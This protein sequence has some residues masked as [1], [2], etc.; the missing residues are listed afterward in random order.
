MQTPDTEEHIQVHLLSSV[1]TCGIRD[2]P[3]TAIL[4]ISTSGGTVHLQMQVSD[5]AALGRRLT[6]D[7]QLLSATALAKA[8]S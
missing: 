3:E 7:A 2:E 6:L 8:A 1:R 5:L 4:E